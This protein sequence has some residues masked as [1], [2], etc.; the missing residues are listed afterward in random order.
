MSKRVFLSK[1]ITVKVINEVGI[2]TKITSFLRDN[3]I[4]LEGIAGYAR[5]IGQD[6]ELIFV[7]NDNVAA[8]EA[9]RKSGYEQISEQDVL[10]VELENRPGML[11]SISEILSANGIN[12]NYIYGTT[13]LSG[14]PAKIVVMTSDNARAF[15]LLND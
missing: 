4:N 11:K 2:L 8:I 7:T 3:N 1:E 9:L 10:M 6:A 14:C 5:Q 12:I 13:C 15:E